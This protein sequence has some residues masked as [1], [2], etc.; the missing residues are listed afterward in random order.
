MTASSRRKFIICLDTALLIIFLLLLAPRLTGLP[1]HEWLG[2]IFFIVLILHLLLSWAWIQSATR[3]FFRTANTRTKVN[4]FLNA[5]LFLLSVS[6]LFSGFLISQV[7]L[8]DFGIKTI[9]DSSWR[10]L[11]N[12]P[13]NFIVLFAGLHIAINWRWI[14]AVFKKRSIN[15]KENSRLP[16]PKIGKIF[17]G[18]AILLL[19]MSIVALLLFSILG[20]PSLERLLNQDE[21]ARFSPEFRHGIVQFLGEAALIAVYAFVAWRWLRIRL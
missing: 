10:A 5:V 3:K 12:I 7:L 1:L 16:S 17:S 11:H 20:K 8:P 2:F 19:A 18:V 21:I 15:T 6:E 9:N 14:V 13:L 4:F